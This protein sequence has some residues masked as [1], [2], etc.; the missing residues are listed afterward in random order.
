MEISTPT[1]TKRNRMTKRA[2]VSTDT[3][4]IRHDS[5]VAKANR[6]RYIKKVLSSDITD[7]M[8]MEMRLA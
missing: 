2:I 1:K 4:V 5:I 6:V 7:F 8:K 3:M